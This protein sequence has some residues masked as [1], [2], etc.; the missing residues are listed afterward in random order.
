MEPAA[1]ITV[2][3]VEQI[4]KATHWPT[5]KSLMWQAAPDWG[6]MWIAETCL[7]AIS[8][9][10]C[11]GTFPANLA[12]TA[13]AH[14]E[15]QY[16]SPYSSNASQSKGL[17]ISICA[18]DYMLTVLRKRMDS[19]AHVLPES[20][21]PPALSTTPVLQQISEELPAAAVLLDTLAV[22]LHKPVEMPQLGP[23]KPG[24]HWQAEVAASHC[25]LLE[26]SAVELQVKVLQRRDEGAV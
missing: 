21:H 25:P 2:W 23:V 17:F 8:I 24:W 5:V 7:S 10:L 4:L 18:S 6:N 13:L 26:Q 9:T 1:S 11:L 3:D 20:Q 12:A 16:T 22:L 14:A 19:A 15:S